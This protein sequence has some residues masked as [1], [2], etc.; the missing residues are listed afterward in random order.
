M[1]VPSPSSETKTPK[2]DTSES[3]N[4]PPIHQV[5][6]P[7]PP[8]PTSTTSTA[9][10]TPNPNPNPPIITPPPPTAP[11]FRPVSAPAPPISA[12]AVPQF[13]PILQN[14]SFPSPAMQSHTYP[15][16][17]GQNAGVHPPG[18]PMMVPGGM[19]PN[20]APMPYPHMPNGYGI[21]PSQP[22]QM[23]PPEIFSYSTGIARYPSPYAP[24]VRPA[25]PQCPPSAM[26]V[27]QPMSRPPIPGIH[28]VPPIAPPMVRPVVP[29]ITPAEKPQTTVY[30][31]KISPTVDNE[32]LLSL[33]RLCGPV[34]SWKRAQDPTDG[35]LRSFGFCEFESA[36]GVLRALRLLNKFNVDGR[37]LVLNV[38]QA[39]REYLERYVEKKKE[40][41]KLKDAEAEGTLKETDNATAVEKEEATKTASADSKKDEYSAGDKENQD[42]AQKLGIITDDDREADKDALEKLT[43]MIEERLKTK[44][45]PP[46]PP[47]PA[48]MDSSAKPKSEFPVKSKDGDS[49][50]D[51]MKSEAAEDKNDDETTSENRLSAEHDKSE[52]SSSD[53][54]RR[55]E[56]RRNRDRERDLKREKER[57]LER[58]EREQERERL[59]RERDRELKIREAERLYKERLREW[60]ARERDKEYLRQHEKDK[61]KDRERERRREIMDQEYE[62]DDENIKKRRRRSSMLEEK[63]KKR[64]REKEDDQR[65]RLRE[66]EEIAEAKKRALEEQQHK[67]D[68]TDA[69]FLQAINEDEKNMMEED[70]ISVEGGQNAT[71]QV[72]VSDPG[73]GDHPGASNG[74]TDESIVNSL[75]VPDTRQNNSNAPARKLGFGLVG[76]GKR[77]TVP[78]VFHEEDDEDLEKEKKMRP[79][80]P[81]DYSTEEIQAVQTPVS[82]ALPH[83]AAAAEFAKRISSGNSKE[84][85]TESERERSKRS[86]HRERDRNDD[87]VSRARDDNRDRAHDKAVDRDKDRERGSDKLKTNESKKLLDAKQL[88]D[89]IPKTKEELFS[90]EINWAVYDEHELHER[91]KPWISKKITEFLGEE[92]PTLV[93][94][95][96]TSTKEHLKAFQMLELL[97]SILD[98]EAEM[99]VLKMWRMLIFE[100]KKVETGLSL[101]SRA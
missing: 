93:D 50:V 67:K 72:C 25:F 91:M 99:F 55:Y 19:Y 20:A 18:V 88:I 76:S 13:Y 35:S 15:P 31:G 29:I 4:P 5:T 10:D 98:D 58:F 48:H 43:N 47:P 79:L 56:D 34:K 81:I 74:V 14:P 41:E 87:E 37:E 52:I 64:L 84:E 32:F 77:T 86:N 26:G 24:M 65:D 95:I 83:L 94:Y 57:E 21:P 12:G 63:K 39:T 11:S 70:G 51:I 28:G 80:V 3:D 1:A 90:Y 101:K 8:P 92:E 49:D 97:Q 45:L 89:M 17:P 60:E 40:R 82:G 59:R 53:K 7:Q 36:E 6:A 2:P 42:A 66:D 69:E 46:P 75:G 78:S 54:S 30:V 16:P 23:P 68:E 38:T 100:I 44:P 61:E 85:K 33:L 62:S 71:V 73:S 22:L 27:V 96:V 9:A